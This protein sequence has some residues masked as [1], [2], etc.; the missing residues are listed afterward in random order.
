MYFTP[1][2][3]LVISSKQV[4]F[5]LGKYLADIM[6]QMLKAHKLLHFFKW[7]FYCSKLAKSYL[8]KWIDQGNW[9]FECNTD[10]NDIL[11]YL[12]STSDSGASRSAIL[13]NRSLRS[14]S[15]HH[16][17]VEE[18][19]T[20]LTLSLRW[21]IPGSLALLSHELLTSTRILYFTLCLMDSD[22]LSEAPKCVKASCC[23]AKIIGFGVNKTW[24]QILSVNEWRGQNI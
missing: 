20:P 14:M 11:S 17:N 12:R 1:L 22:Q 24:V 18:Q 23:R 2:F 13:S 10:N 8:L 7:L 19:D 15:L 6:Q 9:L 16:R 5:S 4:G 3:S 21:P